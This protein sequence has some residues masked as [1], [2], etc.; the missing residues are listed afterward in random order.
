[1]AKK[2]EEQHSG[3]FPFKNV[4]NV[5]NLLIIF[6]YFYLEKVKLVKRK[7]KLNL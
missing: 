2:I 7:K 6:I 1:M 4:D 5:L 3:L